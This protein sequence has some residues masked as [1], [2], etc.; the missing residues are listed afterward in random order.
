V[1]Q[2]GT[3]PALR[4]IPI[5]VRYKANL[6]DTARNP[7]HASTFI[8]QRLIILDIDLKNDPEELHRVL[9]H[10]QF[11]FVWVRLGNPLR[12]SWEALLRSEWQSGSRGETGWSAEWRKRNLSDRDVEH[13]TRTWREYCCESFC[14]TAAWILGGSENEVTLA[15]RHRRERKTWYARNLNGRD[16]PI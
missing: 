14:D 9:L 8:R 16:L 10:E 1:G 5:K 4:G 13:R 6:R 2:V 15:A 12:L 7:A 3:P 11:H